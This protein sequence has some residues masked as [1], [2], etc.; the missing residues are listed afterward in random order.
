MT[1]DTEDYFASKDFTAGELNALVKL[2]GGDQAARRMLRGDLVAVPPDVAEVGKHFWSR[3]GDGGEPVFTKNYERLTAV[4]SLMIGG[5]SKRELYS[6]TYAIAANPSGG[7]SALTLLHKSQFEVVR[8]QREIKTIILSPMDMG[9]T[10]VG[11]RQLLRSRHLDYWSRQN[12]YRLP[13]GY[14]V[15]LL[16]QEAL[17]WKALNPGSLAGKGPLWAGMKP[18]EEFGERKIL[19]MDQ[20]HGD[21][22]LYSEWVS[23]PG[24]H[25]NHE[26]TFRMGQ[27]LLFWL[28]EISET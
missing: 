5:V 18:V 1:A 3:Q 21:S 15:D 28:R 26:Y 11:A 17:F 7:P 14:V 12:A 10:E 4:E 19:A 25:A 27:P 9:R 6:R 2:I 8:K 16:P 13:V 24:D 20:L 22:R 23:G